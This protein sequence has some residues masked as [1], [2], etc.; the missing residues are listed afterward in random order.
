M[1]GECTQRVATRSCPIDSMMMVMVAPV[2]AGSSILDSTFQSK[3][4]NHD[5]KDDA[6]PR[7][8]LQFNTQ[9]IQ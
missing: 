7:K 8:A 3:D 5:D 4:N 2:V 9:P 1:P 6:S